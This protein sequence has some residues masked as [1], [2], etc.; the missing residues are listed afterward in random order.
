[1][2]QN[3]IRYTEVEKEI[4]RLMNDSE[5]ASRTARVVLKSKSGSH[6]GAKK[7]SVAGSIA[8]TIFLSMFLYWYGEGIPSSVK[9]ISAFF[10]GSN[11]NTT[12]GPDIYDEVK[13]QGSEHWEYAD[14]I[15]ES[16]LLTRL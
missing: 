8:A 9:R 2:R 14:S 12:I 11:I 13:L 5:F 16:A 7:L 15:I 6:S 4:N 1:M 10:S 3:D